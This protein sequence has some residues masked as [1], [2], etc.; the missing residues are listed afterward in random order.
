MH[1]AS[2]IKSLISKIED[3]A[4][5]HSAKKVTVV[6]VTLGALSH[7]SPEHFREHYAEA[8]KGTIAEDAT[9]EIETKEGQTDDVYAQEIILDSI[10]IEE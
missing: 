3:T 6:R 9:L 7:C 1:E 4:V 10:E 2:L 5:S 8:A